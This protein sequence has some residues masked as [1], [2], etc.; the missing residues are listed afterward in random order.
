MV[1]LLSKKNFSLVLRWRGEKLDLL[2][3]NM[4]LRPRCVS[5][6]ESLRRWKFFDRSEQSLSFSLHIFFLMLSRKF[7]SVFGD[8][9]SDKYFQKN[10]YF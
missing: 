1:Y 8:K 3:Y 6:H 7:D 10:L 5:F 4:C 2:P 9:V